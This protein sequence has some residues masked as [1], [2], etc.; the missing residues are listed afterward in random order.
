MVQKS[1]MKK[2]DIRWELLRVF[3]SVGAA[4]LR[5]PVEWTSDVIRSGVELKI[6]MYLS[7]NMNCANLLFSSR[8]A[9]SVCLHTQTVFPSLPSPPPLRTTDRRHVADFPS[10]SM[11]CAECPVKFVLMKWIHFSGCSCPLHGQ[12]IVCVCMVSKNAAALFCKV[13]ECERTLLRA[14]C[15]GVGCIF[16]LFLLSVQRQIRS[17]G[18]LIVEKS[19]WRVAVEAVC[20]EPVSAFSTVVQQLNFNAWACAH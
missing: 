16:T 5:G 8:G 17:A 10:C 4:F 3:F 2:K 9:A 15:G 13:E 14:C 11:R 1:P 7:W 6:E 20:V 18:M 12:C 19:N